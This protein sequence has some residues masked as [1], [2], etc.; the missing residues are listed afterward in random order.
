MTAADVL[1]SQ[2]RGGWLLPAAWPVGG[3]AVPR[4]AALRCRQSHSGQRSGGR[5]EHWSLVQLPAPA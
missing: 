5:L 3:P 2:V 4:H 1:H